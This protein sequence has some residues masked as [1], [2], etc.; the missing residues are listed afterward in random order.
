MFELD[1]ARRHVATNRRGTAFTMI[2]VA[3]AVGIIIMSLGLTEGVRV[4]ILENTIEKNAHLI[5]N[6]KNTESYINMYRTLSETTADYPGVLSVSPRLMGQGAV[7][8]QDRVQGVEF[9]GVHPEE[10]NQLMGV[11]DSMIFGNFSDLIFNKKGAILGVKLA[12]NLKIRPGGDFYIY[13]NKNSVRLK[14]IGLLEKGTVK[15]ET[16]VYISLDTAQ[17]LIG[18]GDVVSEIGVKLANFADAPA[19]SRELNGKSPYKTTS[20]QDFSKEIARFV[21]NQNVTNMLFYIFILLISAFVIANTTI[22]VVSRRKKEIGILMALG[23]ERRSILKIF[24]LENMLISVPAG[25][26][27]CLL[28]LGLAKLISLLPLDVTSTGSKAGVLIVAR[29]E[30]FIYAMI[31]ALALNFIAGIYPAYAAARLDPVEA[32]ASE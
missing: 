30:Y 31:F 15:D 21:G 2:S 23:A 17:E 6:P 4:Q 10:E 1:I 24:L 12:Q 29:P 28:G 22:M 32:I 14:V 26:L 11:Q 13:F 27:G 19:L 20:W 3:I 18:Q 9:V 8:F 25:V 7:R 5:I 16:I